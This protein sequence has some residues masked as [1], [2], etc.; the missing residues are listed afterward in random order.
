MN[1]SYFSI[2]PHDPLISRDGRPF[3]YGKRMKSLD[4]FYP[5]V[6]AGTARTLIGKNIG[7]DFKDE[8]LS[9]LK[10]ISVSG[11][12]PLYNNRLY[13]PSPA[14]IAVNELSGKERVTHPISPV[15]YGE[16]EGLNVP[17]G[18]L[19]PAMLPE[20]VKDEFK[21]API[22]PFWSAER[23]TEWLTDYSPLT[24]PPSPET[25]TFDSGYLNFPEKDV[26]THITIESSSGTAEDSKLFQ[27]TAL[28]FSLKNRKEGIRMSFK[29]E[30]N[31]NVINPDFNGK[32]LHTLGGERR[33]SVF[34]KTDRPDGWEC[35]E[36][37]Q[38]SLNS[39]KNMRMI[40]ATP[41]I[42][43]GGWVPGWLKEKDGSLQGEPPSAPEITLKLV[44][45]CI[46]HYKP[47]SGWDMEKNR[48]KPVRRIVPAG[49]VYFFEA[50]GDNKNAGSRLWLK[51]V[52]DDEQDRR[53]GFG[54]ALFGIW[55]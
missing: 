7:I 3:G 23:M 51:S 33:L 44:S 20:D 29:T 32:I 55:K 34:E 28:D 36:P 39:N 42:F 6:I 35:P 15:Q 10:E 46:N 45:A 1:T 37:V 49:S 13:F 43:S 27:T 17:H 16:K 14:D 48:P 38:K 30:Y 21:T 41:A 4:W 11:P 9:R 12:F 25:N 53:D 5:S 18:S 8:N 47:V 24:P 19:L 2:N 40:L 50:I 26:R 54:L 52:C 31:N 22:A